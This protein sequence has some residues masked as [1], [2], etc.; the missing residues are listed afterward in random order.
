MLGKDAIKRELAVVDLDVDSYEQVFDEMGRRFLELGYVNETYLPTIKQREAE[1]PTA[2]PVEPYPI[3]IPHTKASAIIEPFIAPVRLKGT[4]PWGDMS[5]PEH[6]FD[7]KLV[8][9][10]GFKDPQ[11]HIELLQILMHNFQRPAWVE[12][13]FA[14][15]SVDEFYDAFLSLEWTHD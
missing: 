13:L 7:V 11:D 4:V 14:A 15:S 10:L 2:L 12:P 6:T 1:Y 9:M 8:V 5:D 3:A